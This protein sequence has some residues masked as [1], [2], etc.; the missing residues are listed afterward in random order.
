MRARGRTPLQFASGQSMYPMFGRT[1][2]T[3]DGDG[4]SEQ[5]QQSDL[6]SGCHSTAI[7]ICRRDLSGVSLSNL[8]KDNKT[9]SIPR[10]H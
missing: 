10:I 8:G 3:L 2:R 4:N 5:D 1:L 7:V 6:F 9:S